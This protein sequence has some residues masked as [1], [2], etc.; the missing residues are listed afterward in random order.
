MPVC[1]LHSL[2]VLPPSRSSSLLMSVE[3]AAC[4]SSLEL[5][6]GHSFYLF[7]QSPVSVLPVYVLYVSSYV[8]VKGWLGELWC[9]W[10]SFFVFAI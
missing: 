7:T 3:Q 5:V 4:H 6:G 1:D 8:F 9:G 10:L 2:P